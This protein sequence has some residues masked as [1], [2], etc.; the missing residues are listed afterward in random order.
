MNIDSQYRE[1]ISPFNPDPDGPTSPTNY[2]LNLSDPIRNTISINVTA[3]QIPY[4]W[5]LI[6]SEWRSNNSCFYITENSNIPCARLQCRE[7][8]NNN[9]SKTNIT[10]LL[11][12]S[13]ISIVDIR[14]LPL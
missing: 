2:T 13:V 4:T 14:F 9:C 5:Y 1:D 3:Y 11:Y 8:L 10:C 12:S 7:P 6:D